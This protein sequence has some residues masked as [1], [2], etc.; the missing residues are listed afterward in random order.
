MAMTSFPTSPTD[1]QTTVV[2]GIT[3]TY[4][5]TNKKWVAA[6]AQ[7]YNTRTLS[8]YTATSGQTTFTVSTYTVGFVNVYRNGVRLATA[9]YTA[10]TG[11]TIVLADAATAGDT[12]T[13][14]SFYV[15][16]VVNALPLAG[17]TLSGKLTVS[18]T[19]LFSARVE[20]SSTTATVLE[21]SSTSS[22]KVWENAVAGSAATVVDPGAYYVY[23]QGVGPMM[24][25][26]SGGIMKLP[27]GQIKFPAAWN[28]SSDANTLDDYEEGTWTPV[29][30]GLTTAGT[31]TS[32]ASHGGFYVKIGRMVWI[33]ANVNGALAGAVGDM[34]LKGL[35]FTRAAGG[36]TNINNAAYSSIH[37]AYWGGI[38]ID[39]SGGLI[40]PSS[41]MYFHQHTD[42]SSSGASIQVA[43]TNHNLHL[44]GCYF[45][46]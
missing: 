19:D 12:I 26:T 39:I 13:V 35:P 45:T 27:Y 14:E 31:W 40:N 6:S 8:D 37:V 43:N 32:S 29:L 36:Q 15:T 16:S 28:S 34:Q 25:I 33:C 10:T 24:S 1:G 18:T 46:D 5:S 4:S 44:S 21:L 11:T 9:D 42:T 2:G 7:P 41:Q 30:Y 20:S 17:G 38:S 3:Y 22:S 23:Q